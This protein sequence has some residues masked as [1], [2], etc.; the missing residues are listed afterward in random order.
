MAAIATSTKNMIS[1]T[2]SDGP[3]SPEE[4]IGLCLIFFVQTHRDIV[5]ASEEDAVT[6]VVF[7]GLSR[8]YNC[9]STDFLALIGNYRQCLDHTTIC[10]P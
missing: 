10:V 3:K 1:L 9:M 7:L 6:I 2:I 4:F 5:S 8:V